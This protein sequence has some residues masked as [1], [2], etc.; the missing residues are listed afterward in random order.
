MGVAVVVGLRVGF[1]ARGFTEHVVGIVVAL[2]S[3][4][5]GPLDA[6]LDGLA[7]DELLAHDLH[8]LPDRNAD[9]GFA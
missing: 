7:E 2:R 9:D 6:L 3:Q 8:H 1:G 4:L 5:L